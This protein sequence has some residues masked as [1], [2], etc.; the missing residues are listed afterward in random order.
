MKKLFREYLSALKPLPVEGIT[1]LV[2]FRP[3]GFL[4]MKLFCLFPI[5]PNQVSVSAMLTG[6]LCGVCF[7]LGTPQ[8]FLFAGIFYGITHL[9][10]CTD[11]MLARFKKNGT[12]TGRIIDGLIDYVNGVAIFLGLGIGMSRMA[13]SL[14]VSAWLAAALAAISLAFHSILVDYYRSQYFMHAL[15]TF[16]TLDDE[17]AEF[18]TELKKLKR[19]NAQPIAQKII[20]IYLGYCRIQKKFSGKPRK[21]NT[22]QYYQTNKYLMFLWSPVDLST[23]TLVLIVSAVLYKPEIYLIYTILFANLGVLLI[24]PIHNAINKKNEIV[25]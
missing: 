14:P 11:G 2:S 16:N 9:L 21:Y 7:S 17:I 6:I 18:T 8:S 10:D 22:Q 25:S 12:P 1:D 5:T 4:L 23:H 15:G 13:L 20:T 19:Q 3:L 24:A